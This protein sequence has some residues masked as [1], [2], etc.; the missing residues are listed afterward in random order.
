MMVF[1]TFFEI[2]SAISFSFLFF[3]VIPTLLLVKIN[4]K[5]R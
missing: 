3:A 5:R 2:G 4:N 1:K